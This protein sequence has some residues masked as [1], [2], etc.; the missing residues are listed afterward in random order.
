MGPGDAPDGDSCSIGNECA[1]GYCGPAGLRGH[2]AAPG[3]GVAGSSCQG[4]GQCAA[5]LKCSFD[6]QSLFPRCIPAGTFD[7]FKIEARG[8]NM[9]LNARLERN[10]WVAPGGSGDIAHDILVRLR[11]G[12]IEQNDRQELTAYRVGGT[13]AAS[14]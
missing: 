14:R 5:G 7:T 6:G 13:G 11:N 12:A 10:I 9:Q 8:F 3:T 2:C 4:D 1:S